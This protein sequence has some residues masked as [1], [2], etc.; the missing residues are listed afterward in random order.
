MSKVR[1]G[2]ESGKDRLLSK[3]PKNVLMVEQGLRTA[4]RTSQIL[5]EGGEEE[6]AKRERGRKRKERRRGR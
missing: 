4:R 3:S 6:G 2:G 5:T 1:S